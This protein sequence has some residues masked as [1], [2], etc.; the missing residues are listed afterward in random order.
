MVWLR[1]DRDTWRLETMPIDSMIIKLTRGGAGIGPDY[2][3][4]IYG[5]GKVIY[6]GVENVKVKGVVESSIDNNKVISLLSEFK[7]SGFFSLNDTYSIED[8]ITRP[9]NVVSY[10]SQNE[11]VNV[12]ISL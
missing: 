8:S 10:L 6:D 7:E 12:G 2:S 1:S 5:N 9:Y 11:L 4:T 3:L